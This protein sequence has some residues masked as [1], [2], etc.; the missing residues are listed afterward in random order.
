[1]IPPI[2][3]SAKELIVKYPKETDM[4]Y[5]EFLN[6]GFYKILK[7]DYRKSL[8]KEKYFEDQFFNYFPKSDFYTDKEFLDFVKENEKKIISRLSRY[9]WLPK[10]ARILYF[11]VQ[12]LEYYKWFQDKKDTELRKQKEL[13]EKQRKLQEKEEQRNAKKRFQELKGLFDKGPKDLIWKFLLQYKDKTKDFFKQIK[14][15]YSLIKD[16]DISYNEM[17]KYP[18]NKKALNSGI[19]RK[20]VWLAYTKHYAFSDIQMALL[21]DSKIEKI[22]QNDIDVKY[23]DLINRIF[24][25]IGNLEAIDS[26]DLEIGNNGAINGIIKYNGNQSLK[27]ETILAYG[28]VQRPHYRVLLNSKEIN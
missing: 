28:P 20:I 11:W 23:A 15:D 18:S 6:S 9:N 3:K 13:E 10:Q 12:A 14:K 5:D 26:A 21:P 25:K 22:L 27:I 1:M 4:I 16:E 8:T 2:L 24:K 17:V 7:E 19:D